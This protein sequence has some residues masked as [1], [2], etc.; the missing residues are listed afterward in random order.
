MVFLSSGG[1]SKE[2]GGNREMGKIILDRYK[3]T[4]S[5]GEKGAYAVALGLLE[6]LP[7]REFLAKD[8][9]TPGHQ[10]LKGPICTALGLMNDRNAIPAIQA[11]VKQ[12]GDPDLRKRAAIALGLLKDPEAVD[13]LKGVIESNV[14]SKAVLGAATVA[15]GYVGDSRAVPILSQMLSKD[16]SGVYFSKNVT[17]AFATVALGF[18]GDKDPIPMLSKVQENSNYLAQTAALSELLTIL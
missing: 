12:R 9:D 1:V 18:L 16:D 15:L 17:R 10:A 13:T 5:D 6:H 8:L 11:L 14:K 4:K 7:A 2:D 3:S